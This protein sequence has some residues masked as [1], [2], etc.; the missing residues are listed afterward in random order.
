[1]GIF[2]AVDLLW[3]PLSRLTF[4]PSNWERLLATGVLTGTI[5]C[6]PLLLMSRVRARPELSAGILTRGA[7]ALS[8]LVH[9]S[10]IIICLGIVGITFSYLSTSLALPFRDAELAMIDRHFGFNW[11]AFLHWTN[12]YPWLA[13]ILRGAYHTAGPQLLA[14]LLFL[15][16]TRSARR[17]HEFVSVLALGSLL[18]AIGMT[19]VAAEGA[20]AYFSPAAASFS[21]YS[22]RSGIW[23]LETLRALRTSSAPVLEFA[24][25]QGLVTF[26]SFHTVLAIITPY[27]VRDWPRIALGATLLNSI[28]LVGTISE[29][30]HH[31]IDII[32][33]AAAAALAIVTVRA[34]TVRHTARSRQASKRQPLGQR[35]Y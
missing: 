16:A 21:N 9:A 34:I 22:Q 23:H 31:L 24:S 2:L 8:L 14:V 30:G 15:S 28:V 26:P 33:G 12:S 27:A 32:A 7:E 18:T 25:A 6:V 1:V 13:I 10:A 3:F 20:Y 11:P 5:S 19:L 35:D 17:L 4:A 29:G